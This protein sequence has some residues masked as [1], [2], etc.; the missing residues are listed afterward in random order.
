MEPSLN[1]LESFHLTGRTALVTGGTRG[2]GAA[3]A[4]GFADAGARVI[5]VARNADATIPADLSKPG[6]A[7]RVAA[8]AGPV[9]ILVNDAGFIRRAPVLEYSEEDWDAVL[10]IQLKAVF[11]LSQATARGMKDRGWGRIV[12]V[13]SLL[14]FQGGIT[15]PAYAAAK[16]AV[17]Q[18]TKAFANELAA[19][20]VCVNAIAPGY[21]RTESTAALQNDAARNRQ[22]L[23]R[24]PAGRWGEPQDLV[25][26][27]VFLSS[28]ASAYV[29]GHILI[30]DGGWMAR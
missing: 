22:I 19:F 26:A 28:P 29:N 20:G 30:V 2:I 18:L 24:I 1:I 8:A 23:E 10:Q 6:E 17:A 12:N 4:A 14:S 7:L 21:I 13:A 9:D 5:T 16:G 25:G 11:Q 27:V 15:V 3:I